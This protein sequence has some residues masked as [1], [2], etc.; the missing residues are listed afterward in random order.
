[1]Y[2]LY[3]DEVGTDDLN[4]LENDNH[5]YLSL[6]GVAMRITDAR[7]DLTPK[8]NWVKKE[9]FNHDPDDP[10]IFHRR[11]IVQRKEKFGALNNAAKADLFDRAMLRIYRTCPYVVITCLIDKLEASKKDKWREKHPYDYLMQIIVE[12]YA[13]FLIRMESVG[14]I[15]PEG[16]MGKKDQ[17]LQEAYEQV[18]VAG[19]YY[20]SPEK[21]CFR[22]PSK[23]LKIRYKKDNIAG[24]QL[25]DLLAHPSR[26]FFLPRRIKP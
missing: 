5:R 12:K 4:D 6:T 13:R 9:V 11:K 20:F 3:V 18:R 26:S 7:D 19:N 8:M 2:R 17:R 1:M 15:M 22:I 14:D 21:I 10:L 24:L 16:R 23:N 25:S